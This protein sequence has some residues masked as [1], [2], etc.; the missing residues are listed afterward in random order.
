MAP[1]FE[2]EAKNKKGEK[3]SGELT[4]EQSSQAV[5][6]L[7]E[8][9][10]F[11]TSIKKKLEKKDIKEFL[12]FNKRVK[13]NDLAVFSQ[14]FSAMI[15]AGITVVDSLEILREQIEHTKLK[16]VIINIQEEV[17]T[18]TSLSEA[19]GKHPDVFPDLYCQMVKAGETGG[20]LDKVLIQLAEHYERQDEINGKIKSSLYYPLTIMLVAVVVVVFLM[21]QVVPQFVSM[22][23]SFG[24]ILPLPTRILLS[25]SGFL[26]KYWWIV[27]LFIFL[28]LILIFKYI[29]TP[30]GK[31]KFDQVMLKLPVIGKMMKKIYLSRFANTL[32]ILLGSGV[33]LLSAL[34]IVEDIISNKVFAR[35]LTEV[36]SQVR[37]GA[38]FSEPLISTKLF[39]GMVIQMIKVGEEA[40]TLENMLKK[41]SVYYDREVENSIDSSISLI[42][43]VMIVILALVVGFIVVSIVMPMFDM[44]QF[45]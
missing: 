20:I 24:G 28:L 15:N 18:G 10:Y 5:K 17:E 23:A 19:M 27:F 43:P 37:E 1:V 34:T 41:I 8:K 36:R 7:R 33:S 31:Y 3:I 39:P 45:F 29:Q 44:F 32:S 35:A 21:I 2:Y 16:E 11:V 30:E 9:G 38:T 13:T 26:Q 25:V 14:Q 6:Q 40:G 12:K 22:F 4:A 42:E